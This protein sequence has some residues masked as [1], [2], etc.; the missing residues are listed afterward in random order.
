MTLILYPTYFSRLVEESSCKFV[1]A[2]CKSVRVKTWSK[3]I[4]PVTADRDSASGDC[5]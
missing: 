2:E 4:L 3:V 5:V 1:T